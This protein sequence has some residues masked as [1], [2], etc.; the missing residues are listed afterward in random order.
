M[1]PKR[2]FLRLPERWHRTPRFDRWHH[3]SERCDVCAAIFTLAREFGLA[4][5][6]EGVE[7]DEQCQFLEDNGCQFEPPIPTP[8]K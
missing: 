7:T 1:T 5:I 2:S 6:A 3:R 8:H 4:V